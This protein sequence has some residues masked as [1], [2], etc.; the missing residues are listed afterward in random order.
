MDPPENV[1]IKRDMKEIFE[2]KL[3]QTSFLNP[4]AGM[5]T[6]FG[7]LETNYIRLDFEY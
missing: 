4:I 6:E 7:S 2:V 1:P 5:A 3:R